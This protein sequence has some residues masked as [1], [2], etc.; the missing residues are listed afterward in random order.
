M[1]RHRE[2]Q[3]D[4]LLLGAREMNKNRRH[5]DQT[6]AGFLRCSSPTR[7]K[8][9]QRAAKRVGDG[10]PFGVGEAAP[11]DHPMG[12]RTSTARTTISPCAIDPSISS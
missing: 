11:Q 8:N 7:V 3:M 9:Q 6:N 2:A 12:R 4:L 5:R 10:L 1:A